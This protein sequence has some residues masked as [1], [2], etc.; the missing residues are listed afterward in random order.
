MEITVKI[1]VNLDKIKMDFINLAGL[2]NSSMQLIKIARENAPIDTST[3]KKSIGKNKPVSLGDK[4]VIL[5]PDKIGSRKVVYAQ[6]R[7]YENKKNP[8]KKFYMKRTYEKAGEIVNAE[9]K[10]AVDRAIE[11][12]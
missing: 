9:F 11:S 12:L 4:E 5:G 8:H 6:R 7:E 2:E 1:N 3:L 10:K